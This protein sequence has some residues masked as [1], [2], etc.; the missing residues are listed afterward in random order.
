MCKIMMCGSED[1]VE[2]SGM[3]LCGF[4]HI[5]DAL[6]ETMVLCLVSCLSLSDD[7]THLD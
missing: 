7:C 6:G 5:I 1:K 3:F 4:F 2:G